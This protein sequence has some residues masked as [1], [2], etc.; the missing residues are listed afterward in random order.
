MEIELRRSYARKLAI[1]Y[2]REH[3]LRIENIIAKYER[4]RVKWYMRKKLIHVGYY[5]LDPTG[6]TAVKAIYFR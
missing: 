3:D 4:R 2:A 1:K 5:I 6:S